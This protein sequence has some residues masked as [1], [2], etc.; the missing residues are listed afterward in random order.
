MTLLFVDRTEFYDQVGVVR[1]VMQNH[2]TEIMTLIAM[3]LP[4]ED[5]NIQT[6][7][8][9]KQA[10]LKDVIAIDEWSTV[11]GQYD[12]YVGEVIS[13]KKVN[14]TEIDESKTATFGAS[15][16]YIDSERWRHVPFILMSGKKLDDKSSYVKIVF[17]NNRVCVKQSAE[18]DQRTYMMFVISQHGWSNTILLSNSLSQPETIPGWRLDHTKSQD[19]MLLGENISDCHRLVT[20]RHHSEAYTTLIEAVYEGQRHLFTNTPNLLTSWD[21]WSNL[22]KKLDKKTPLKYTHSDQLA[23][24]V[25]GKTLEFVKPQPNEQDSDIETSSKIRQIGSEFRGDRLVVKDSGELMRQLASDIQSSAVSSIED[26]GVFHLALSGGYSPRPLLTYMV[27]S[28]VTFPWKHTHIW[29]VD[30]RCVE[31]KSKHSN[32]NMIQ[33]LLLNHVR[34]PHNNVHPMPVHLLEDLCDSKYNGD[35]LYEAIINRHVINNTLDYIVLGMGQDGH[36]ASL[37]P[38]DDALNTNNKLVTYTQ[39]TKS[40]V[41][42]PKRMTMTLPLI[43]RARNVSIIVSGQSKHKVLQ[44]ISQSQLQDLPVL[45]VKPKQLTWYIDYHA[46]FG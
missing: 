38:L 10:L 24:K 25:I 3:E 20:N 13:E 6:M 12:S 15:V 16:V 41:V 42:S 27:N 40:Q 17:K 1:D 11:I 35:L 43:N 33:E 37:F 30:E 22:V 23:F 32:F 19:S 44:E 21:I 18:C 14:G 34:I 29:Q 39:V 31:T 45:K 8:R 36:T 7:L 2:L 9:K 4:P 46:Y 28:L 5:A 26:R